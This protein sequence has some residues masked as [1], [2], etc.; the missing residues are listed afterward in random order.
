M[1]F[2]KYKNQ[3]VSF[4]KSEADLPECRDKSEVCSKVDL[5]GDP[6]VERQCRCASG[7]SCSRS[8][9]A[10]DGHT[11]V[12]KTRQYKLCEPVKRLPVCRYFK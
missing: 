4:Q 5:Y 7:R 6:W 12:D 10:D 2:E 8:L 3:F 1:T 9:H 11:I